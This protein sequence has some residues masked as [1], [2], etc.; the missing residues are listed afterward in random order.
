MHVL[1]KQL[2]LME[3]GFGLLIP[4]EPSFLLSTELMT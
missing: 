2:A 3:I 4:I 1:I